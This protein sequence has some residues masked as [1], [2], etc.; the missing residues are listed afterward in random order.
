MDN[1]PHKKDEPTRFV[2]ISVAVLIRDLSNAMQ[3]FV[4]E[5]VKVCSVANP[6]SACAA[7][8]RTDSHW[9]SM[10]ASSQGT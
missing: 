7:G 5:M 1:G 4:N 8:Q 9:P 2:L 10:C 3:K 6:A